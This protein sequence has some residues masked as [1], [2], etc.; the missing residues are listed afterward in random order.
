M[1]HL[2]QG[3]VIRV[4]SVHEHCMYIINISL[5]NGLYSQRMT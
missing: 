1:F 4:Q 3:S 2:L 5:L